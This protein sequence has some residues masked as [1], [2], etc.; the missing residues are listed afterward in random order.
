MTKNL[1]KK[2]TKLLNIMIK[3]KQLF[4]SFVFLSAL[5]ISLFAFPVNASQTGWKKAYGGASDDY[6][7]DLIETADGGFAILGYTESFGAGKSDFWL[8]KTDSNGNMEWN[9]T[10]GGPDVDFAHSLI[11]TSDGGYALAGST[12]FSGEDFWL[13]KTDAYGNM[14]WN[15]TYGGEKHEVAYDLVEASDGGYALA[16]EV[17]PFT[18]SGEPDCWLVKT[19]E[20]G[21]MEWNQTYGGEEHD[22][23]S[24]LIQTSDGGYALVGET[25]ARNS[26]TNL[27][28]SDSL[29]IKT[30]SNGIMEWNQTYGTGYSNDNSRSLLE[31]P[32]GGYVLPVMMEMVVQDGVDGFGIVKTDEVGN[33]DWSKTYLETWVSELNSLI[34][35]SDGGYVVT[36][37]AARLLLIKIDVQGNVE[38]TRQYGG[39]RVDKGAS[40]VETSDGGFAAVGNTASYATDYDL[41]GSDVFFVKTDAQGW[42]PYFYMRIKE[43]GTVEGTD[44]IQK[45]GNVY[46]FTDDIFVDY[47]SVELDNII[48]DGNGYSLS[49]YGVYGAGTGFDLTDR[50]NVTIKNTTFHNL[51]TAIRLQDSFF[52]N[53][54]ENVFTE[55]LEAISMSDSY[56]NVISGNIFQGNIR[57]AIDFFAGAHNMISENIIT[58]NKEGIQMFGSHNTI[59]RNVIANNT[60]NGFVVRD[61]SQYNFIRENTIANQPYGIHITHS[62]YN[63]IFWNNIT[64]N[65]VG[66]YFYKYSSNN[67]IYSN[68]FVNNEQQIVINLEYATQGSINTWEDSGE[69]NYWSNYN[70]TDGN[71]DGIGDSPYIIDENNQDNNP[72]V[73]YYSIPEFPLWTILPLLITTTLAAVI[74]RKR[75][76][77]TSQSRPSY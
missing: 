44:K 2:I 40:V 39:A 27:I 1:L 3:Q 63:D 59:A 65:V 66:M 57:I 8:I 46:T 9:K 51:S 38:W 72:L 53:I 61:S 19:D 5:S 28:Q 29:L 76:G 36:G 24:S 47:F 73:K 52:N 55:N 7:T 34:R 14:E 32:D 30:D 43:D 67:T 26:S 60:D 48:I 56:D 54:T 74:Y 42:A 25:T 31:R 75:L 70:G 17:D 64:D 77:N 68:N 22:S 71:S 16:G 6:G 23:V 15:Q 62:T 21:N 4:L 12:R 69:G 13:V 35:T 50:H 20:F 10:Y 41:Y 45:N 58:D 11:Q 18:L 33:V 37:W 49:G